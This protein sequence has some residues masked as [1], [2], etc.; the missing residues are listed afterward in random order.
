MIRPEIAD[1]DQLDE[2]IGPYLGM[3]IGQPAVLDSLSGDPIALVLIAD[4]IAH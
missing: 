2:R 4:E 1:L 3:V